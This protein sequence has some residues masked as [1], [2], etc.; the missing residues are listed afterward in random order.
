RAP[1][2]TPPPPP[3]AAGP[4]LAPGV[5]GQPA[6]VAGRPPLGR[7]P[8]PRVIGEPGQAGEP[9]PLGVVKGR[10]GVVAAQLV[11]PAGTPPPPAAASRPGPGS[12]PWTQ[13]YEP[14]AAACS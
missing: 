12:R 4:A 11:S 9:R 10:L 1:V 5:A 7:H 3:V 14:A 8:G 6:L 2:P 13:C